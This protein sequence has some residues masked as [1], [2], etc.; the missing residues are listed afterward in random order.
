MKLF[1]NETF[2]VKRISTVGRYTSATEQ[3]GRR[4]KIYSSSPVLYEIIFNISGKSTVYFNGKTL[5][6]TP[7]SIRYLPKGNFDGEYKVEV[8]EEGVCIDIFF[9]TDDPMPSSAM[10]VYDV[11]ELKNSF[12]KIY[13]I[14]LSKE[15]GYYARAMSLLYGIIAALKKKSESYMP[16]DKRGRLETAR[17]YIVENFKSKD[18]DFSELCESTGLSYSYFKELFVS[19]YGMPPVKYL[20]NMRLEY[21]KELLITKRYS[22]SETAEMCGF[23]NVYYFSSVFKKHI[24]VSPKS[25]KG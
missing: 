7:G 10:C 23:E 2:N 6:N 19:C 18:F 16:S 22:V 25:Y 20:T 24:G 5:E 17:R 12:E 8:E 21:A 14:W 1:S 9:D 11:E 13:N 3:G 15:P 4:V